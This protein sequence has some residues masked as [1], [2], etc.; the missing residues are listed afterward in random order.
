MRAAPEPS[1]P[2]YRHVRHCGSP[3]DDRRK[4]IVLVG[5]TLGVDLGT[6]Y[7]AAAIAR[8]GRAEVVSLGTQSLAIPSVVLLAAGGEV[9]VGEAAERRALSEPGRTAREF[10]RRLG[11]PTPLLLGGTPYGAESLMAHLLKAIVGKVVELEGGAPD[12]IV[13]THPANY[14]P[15]KLD[16]LTETVRLADV[17]AVHF[18]TEPEAAA[19]QYANRERLE[20]GEVVAVYD[21]G[22]GTFDAAVLRKTETGFE[23]LGT[24]EGMERIGGIDFDQAIFGFVDD[25]LDGALSDLDPGD[26]SVLPAVARLR[27]ECRRAKEALSV[28]TD[29]SIPVLLPNLQTEVRLTRSEFEAMI[30]PR[31]EETIAALQ[32]ALRSSEVPLEAVARILLVGGS[33]RIPLVGLMVRSATNRPVALDAHPKFAIATGAA[34]AGEAL[35]AQAKAEAAAAR[36]A[37]AEAEAR[38]ARLAAAQE[39]AAR[40]AAAEQQAAAQR[41]AEARREAEAEQRAAQQEAEARREVEARQAAAAEH[42]PPAVAPS[43][44]APAGPPPADPPPRPAAAPAPRSKTPFIAGGAVAALVVAAGAVYALTG[45][46]DEGGRTTTTLAA[47]MSTTASTTTTLVDPDF[48]V[49]DFSDPGVG[50]PAGDFEAATVGVVDGSYRMAVNRAGFLQRSETAFRSDL[51]TIE[52]VVVEAD[53]TPDSEAVSAGLVCHGQGGQ[54][55][56]YLAVVDGAGRW[57]LYRGSS[58]LAEGQAA[59]PSAPTRRLRLECGTAAAGGVR[60]SFQVDGLPLGEHTDASPLPPGQV[61]MAVG[62]HDRAAEVRFDNFRA[63]RRAG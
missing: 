27:E 55:G 39:E 49:D 22:G 54:E 44:P 24:P 37:A 47:G 14:G 1:R 61:G 21:F 42:A 36:Q 50:W 6:T 63:T 58:V 60:L 32:R 40:Q 18:L 5:Y 38:E 29:A 15:Y 7:S 11:D 56:Y 2:G 62:T 10:K 48:I 3:A 26:A 34:L 31:V 52:D 25:A 28:D 17:G 33:S 51:R 4:G 46:G 53:A 45:G 8:D 57:G 59:L 30:A 9:L 41:E 13:V 23:V 19:I 16:L 35:F 12:L 20:P 43:P